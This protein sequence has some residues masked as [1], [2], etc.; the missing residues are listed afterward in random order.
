MGRTQKTYR[1]R[2]RE[3][4][5]IYRKKLGKILSE[6]ELS[7]FDDIWAEAHMLSGAASVVPWVKTTD[8]I[9]LTMMIKLLAKIRKIENKLKPQ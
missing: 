6:Q 7:E 3:Q 1:T 5:H 4:Y 8:I 2:V 9:L